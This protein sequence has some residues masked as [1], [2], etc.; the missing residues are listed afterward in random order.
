MSTYAI[1]DVQ[2]CY[3]PLQ[4]LLDKINFDTAADTLW[5][6]GDLVNRGPQSLETLRFVKSLGNNAVT[7]LGN[8]DIHLLALHYGL[9]AREKDPTLEQVLDAADANELISWL[10]TLPV[11]HTEHDYVL[12]HAGIHPQWS[13]ELAASLAREIEAGLQ[14]VNSS[15]GLAKLYGPSE[16]SWKQAEKSENRLRYAVNCFTRMRYCSNDAEPDFRHSCEPGAQ[17]AGLQPWFNINQRQAAGSKIIF[18][19]WAALGVMQQ[20]GIHA[21]DSGCV[22]GN[23]LTAMNLQDESLHQVPCTRA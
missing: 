21:L 17:P 9:R 22:W 14:L 5:F 15:T 6:A 20:N 7:V 3:E 23:A 8:H 2:G 13:I 16:G 18:G 11:M 4:R 12:V 19:H 10:Q 1:G